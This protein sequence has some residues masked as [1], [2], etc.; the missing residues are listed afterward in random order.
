MQFLPVNEN[1][2]VSC[3]KYEILN[4][5]FLTVM[6]NVTLVCTELCADSLNLNSASLE[7]TGI[8]GIS[9]SL[10]HSQL[11]Q[12]RKMQTTNNHCSDDTALNSGRSE[13]NA[14]TSA[15]LCKICEK[16][17]KELTKLTPTYRII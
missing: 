8:S 13:T 4:C 16:P 17:S 2:L 1:I 10:L 14:L 11:M 5:M 6:K 12:Y 15:F 3:Q 9:T 7:I